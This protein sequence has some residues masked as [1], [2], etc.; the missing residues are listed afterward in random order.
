MEVETAPRNSGKY[1]QAANLMANELLLERRG[2]RV[3]QYALLWT[4]FGFLFALGRYAALISSHR[5]IHYGRIIYLSLIPWYCWGL[6]AFLVTRL[7]RRFPLERNRVGRNLLTHFIAS[8]AISTVPGIAMALSYKLLYEQRFEL[9]A[10]IPLIVVEINYNLMVYWVIVAVFHAIEMYR[11][12]HAQELLN[13]QIQAHLTQS[14]LEVLKAQLQPHFLFNTLNT[15]TGLIEEDPRKAQTMVC[16]LSDLLRVSLDSSGEQKVPF[17]NE[18]E[19]L[20]KYLEIEQCRFED[21]LSVHIDYDPGISEARIPNFILQ[22]LVENAVRHSMYQKTGTCRIGISA[23]RQ[24]DRLVISI[25]DNGPGLTDPSG[26][27]L[28]KGLGLSNTKER[29]DRM[30]GSAQCLAFSQTPCGGLTV[31]LSIPYE[32]L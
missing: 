4:G 10:D 3:L 28:K 17:F 9:Y 8:V 19:L 11:R 26:P 21:R 14:R 12:Y 31:S 27:T 23:Y 15:V 7:A 13:A 22:P 30:Y 6:L 5:D 18:I 2:I 24:D 29:L 25:S 16:R 20:N 1:K 32:T